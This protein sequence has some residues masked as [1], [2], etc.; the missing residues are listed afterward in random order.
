[1]DKKPQQC[2]AE[3]Q[4]GDAMPGVHRARFTP[5]HLRAGGLAKKYSPTGTNSVTSRVPGRCARVRGPS[6]AGRC[7]KNSVK[8]GGTTDQRFHQARRQ[9]ERAVHVLRQFQNLA[10]AL[11]DPC[12]EE[13]DESDEGRERGIGHEEQQILPARNAATSNRQGR[14]WCAGKQP[15]HGLPPT[16]S[17]SG[18][19]CVPGRNA[20]AAA[21]R[22][23]VAVAIGV[24][25]VRVMMEI[26]SGFSTT[27]ACCPRIIAST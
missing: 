16:S 23:L 15:S 27:S 4:V 22:E 20:A 26:T 12:I 9:I 8:P 7:R 2:C 18:R 17:S 19:S 14:P 25:V 13:V 24:H 10:C 6:Q 5:A 3:K 1:M 21:G 11:P